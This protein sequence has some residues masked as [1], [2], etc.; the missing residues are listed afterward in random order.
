MCLK[1]ICILGCFLFLVC[2]IEH[3]NVFAY[4]MAKLSRYRTANRFLLS[5]QLGSVP[6]SLSVRCS[7]ATTSINEKEVN[8]QYA[9]WASKRGVRFP[10][11]E[12]CDFEGL[13][14]VK[15]RESISAGDILVE[16]PLSAVL[17][18]GDA[19]PCPMPEWLDARFWYVS[20]LHARLAMLLLHE[21][22]K[23][24]ASDYHPWIRAMPPSHDD[25]LQR[26]TDE[27][28]AE[29]QDDTLAS[30][31]RRQREL[32]DSVYATLKQLSPRTPVSLPEFR[33]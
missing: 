15:A 5:R 8:D 7:T 9:R 18:V 2:L 16:F 26:W 10:K 11:I 6:A 14:G 24:A 17:C 33:W 13:R 29:L 27:E 22:S 3:E 28:L 31:A 32:I 4:P 21:A 23:G 12:P 20:S 1:S 19:Q 30:E 25:K